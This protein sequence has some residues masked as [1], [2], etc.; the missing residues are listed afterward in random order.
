M[1]RN[2]EVPISFFKLKPCKHEHYTIWR[3]QENSIFEA[4]KIK[5][6]QL[7]VF[8]MHLINPIVNYLIYRKYGVLLHFFF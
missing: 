5:L 8:F 6:N 3:K 2:L 4:V 1:N 7:Y